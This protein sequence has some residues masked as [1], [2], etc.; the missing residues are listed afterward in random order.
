MPGIDHLSIDGAV[1]EAGD[2]ARARHPGRA[3]VRPA[4]RA[5]T[6]E[7]SG[8]WDDEGV[9]PARDARDQGRAS[10]PAGHHR[11]LPVRVHDARP[12]RRAARRRRRRQRRDARAARPH[13]RLAGRGGRRRR[14]AER[15]DGRP[16][17]RAARRARRARASP[18]RRSS[19]TA[20]STPPP[21][22]ARSARPPTRRPQCGDRTRLPDGSGQRARGGAR[23]ASST[24]RR[25][26]TW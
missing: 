10:R 21:S 25:A 6:S 4:R 17:G 9:D 1:E 7:G 2:R 24:S 14:R 22:T 3:A 20:P 11:P 5:R 13:R 12:L 16:R 15:H 8:A 23:G 26:P 19:P 18:R